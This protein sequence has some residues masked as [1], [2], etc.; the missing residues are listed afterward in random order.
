M[1][2]NPQ[3]WLLCISWNWSLNVLK[4]FFQKYD[5]LV[6]SI[7]LKQTI[8]PEPSLYS[9][10]NGGCL[11][12]HS[13]WNQVFWNV[14]DDFNVCF[15]FTLQIGFVLYPPSGGPAWDLLD[16]DNIKFLTI[17]FCWH[18]AFSFIIIGVLYAFVIW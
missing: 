10:D 17:C 5:L 16:H 14:A 2:T 8:K 18:Y 9:S 1:S 12:Y 3:R 11:G 15:C 13:S 4:N 6:L 7:L